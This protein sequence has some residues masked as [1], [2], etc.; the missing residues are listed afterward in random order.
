MISF[1]VIEFINEQA[2]GGINEEA[3]GAVNK[4]FT[5]KTPDWIIFYNWASLSFTSIDKKLPYKKIIT[6]DDI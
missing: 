5:K 3:I 6:F 2:I 1:P 4:P